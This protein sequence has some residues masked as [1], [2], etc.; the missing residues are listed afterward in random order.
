[1]MMEGL[2]VNNGRCRSSFRDPS[3]FLFWRNGAL[4]RQINT[5]YQETY[6]LLKASA[7][8]DTLVKSG[9][10]IPHEEVAIEPELRNVRIQLFSLP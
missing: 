4:Y 5:C 7:L 8:Y 6:G 1:M 2:S 9:K 3:G 10:L